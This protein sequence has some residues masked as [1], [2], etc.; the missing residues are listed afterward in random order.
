MAKIVPSKEIF[1]RE[2]FIFWC[3]ACA[4]RHWVTTGEGRPSWSVSGSVEAPT[5]A[6]S[7]KVTGGPRD[8]PTC[9]HFHVRGGTIEYC[10]DCTHAMNSQTVPMVEVDREGLPL[11]PR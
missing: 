9:C 8:K 6:P 5:F 1:R 3:P 2:G 11:A 10:N 7:V 4:D